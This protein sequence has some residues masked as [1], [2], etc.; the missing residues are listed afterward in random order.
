MDTGVTPYLKQRIPAGAA[1][2]GK[3]V[4]LFLH[5]FSVPTAQAFDVPGFLWMDHLAGTGVC[6]F[7]LD[8]RGFGQSSRPPEMSQPA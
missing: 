2:C 5:L 4:A 8:F 6:S 3:D 1:G 7:A